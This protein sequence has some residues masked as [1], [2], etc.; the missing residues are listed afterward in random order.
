M[1]YRQ[2]HAFIAVFEERNI[3]GAARRLCLTQ[4]ALSATIKMLED[5]LG[6]PLFLRQPRGVEVTQDARI[7]YPHARRMVAE[8]DTLTCSFRRERHR[9]PLNIGIE[10]DIA[11]SQLNAFLQHIRDPEFCL[12]VTLEPG[13]TGDIRLGC[14]ELRCEDE[15]F[16]PLHTEPFILALPGDH[17]LTEK[18]TVTEADLHGLCWVMCPELTSHQRLLP[19]YGA[20]ANSPAA[21]AGTYSLALGL[22]TQGLGVAI[23]PELLAREH[24]QVVTRALPGHPLSRRTGV[25]YAVQSLSFPAVDQFIQHLMRIP[26]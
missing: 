4:P 20:T 19:V 21:N 23:V 16:L 2:L 6:T 24:S 11:D 1:D 26:C 10:H 22:V 25:C 18:T 15:L 8:L 9:Q 5:D 17:P 12:L 7:L 14:E 13:C 3:T